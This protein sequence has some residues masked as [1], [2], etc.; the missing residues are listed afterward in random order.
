MCQVPVSQIL[1]HRGQY[2]SPQFGLIVKSNIYQYFQYTEASL[3]PTLLC[4]I[5]APL[6]K[7]VKI[8][9]SDTFTKHQHIQQP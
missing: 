5:I 7:N 2:A 3:V 9:T 6:H 4:A 1:K 8:C